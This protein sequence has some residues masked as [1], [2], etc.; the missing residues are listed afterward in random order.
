MELSHSWYSQ[1]SGAMQVQ[2]WQE[3]MGD[4]LEESKHMHRFDQSD[5]GSGNVLGNIQMTQ[6]LHLLE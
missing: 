2:V 5:D 4:P 1:L 3:L 6:Y